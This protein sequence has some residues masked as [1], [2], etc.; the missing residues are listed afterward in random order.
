MNVNNIEDEFCRSTT[1]THAAIKFHI[2]N[3]KW[4]GV[5]VY[6]RTGKRLKKKYIEIN[7][8]L[9]KVGW[10]LLCFDR[11]KPYQNITTFRI[12]P[13]E[14]ISIK[15][16]TKLPGHDMSLYPVTMDFRHKCRFGINTPQA[17]EN[18]LYDVKIGDITLSPRW[19]SNETAWKIV[20]SIIEQVQK[21]KK[22]YLY[23]AGNMGPREADKLLEKDNRNWVDSSE[24]YHEYN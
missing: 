4:K 22:L 23:S 3:D 5:L 11:K 21:T 19:D 17:Y 6:V 7:L 16:N 13:F 18:L 20:N 10:Q 12:Q 1:E 14:G 2:H 9:K 15:F 8:V 24:I